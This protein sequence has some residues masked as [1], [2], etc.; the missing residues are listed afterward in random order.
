[1]KKIDL[2][3]ALLLAT[4][5]F[6]G[7]LLLVPYQLDTLRL[8]N[9]PVDYAKIIGE[10]PLPISVLTLISAVQLSIISFILAFLG[11]KVARKTGFS[12]SILESILKKGKK[13]VF[14]GK[15]IWLSVLFGAIT[16]FIL[17]GADKFYFQNLIPKLANSEPEISLLGL[18]AGVLYGGVFEEILMRLLFMSLLVWGLQKVF[19][20]NKEKNDGWIY[21]FSNFIAAIAFAA[22]HLPA[23][24]MFFGELTGILILRCF[25]INGIGGIFWG[26]LYWKKG[27]EYAIISHMFAHITMQLLFIPL[28]Y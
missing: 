11:L 24:K 15:S 25:L 3:I 20:R 21:W 6:A 10:I 8:M 19:N 7:G 13:V 9:G 5:C 14:H 22:G 12:F 18:F 16:G 4:I 1:M 26:F 28:F 2:K 27:L 23:T 17:A